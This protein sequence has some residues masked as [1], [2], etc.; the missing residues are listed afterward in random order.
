MLFYEIS[1]RHKIAA[2]RMQF[3]QFLKR[4]LASF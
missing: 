1:V 3:D 4:S 2:L